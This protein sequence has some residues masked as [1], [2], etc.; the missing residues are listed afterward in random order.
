MKQSYHEKYTSNKSQ[1]QNEQL[2]VDDD[3]EITD[4]TDP[5]FLKQTNEEDED[6]G[7]NENDDQEDNDS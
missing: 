3:P 4:E 7:Q 2:Y 5:N 6:E 1:F